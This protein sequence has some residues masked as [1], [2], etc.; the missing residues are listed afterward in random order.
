MMTFQ[1]YLPLFRLSAFMPS[2]S[3]GRLQKTSA[4]PSQSSERGLSFF[5]VGRGSNFHPARYAHRQKGTVIQNN[6]RHPQLSSRSA[7]SDVPN[8]GAMTMATPIVPMTRP[9]RSRPTT[10]PR[11]VCPAGT[12][13]PPARPCII[14]AASS[15]SKRGERA[16]TAEKIANKI[17]P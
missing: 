10:R 6:P 16:Q 17:S 9:R 7:P 14:L 2:I 15:T 3:I 5:I 13:N 1:P 12:S 11:I 4:S 8:K